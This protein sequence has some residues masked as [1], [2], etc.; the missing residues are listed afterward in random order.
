MS[1][2]RTQLKK[3]GITFDDFWAWAEKASKGPL[4]SIF[5]SYDLSLR[6]IE[7]AHARLEAFVMSNINKPDFE[8]MLVK[9]EAQVE[10]LQRQSLTRLERLF[11]AY[12]KATSERTQPGRPQGSRQ[13]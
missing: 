7:V 1:L 4:K 9:R 3:H 6:R 8:S 13:I 10:R 5:D 2:V 11:T 12:K